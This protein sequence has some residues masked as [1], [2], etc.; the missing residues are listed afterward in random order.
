M[1][2]SG[3]SDISSRSTKAA[4]LRAEGGYIR[5]MRS[6]HGITTMSHFC[7]HIVHGRALSSSRPF[8]AWLPLMPGD[9]QVYVIFVWLDMM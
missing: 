7:A 3:L 2:T 6:A 1:G 4:G 5:K 9:I 8:N